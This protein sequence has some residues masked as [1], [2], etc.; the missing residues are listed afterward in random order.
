MDST[1]LK[2][3]KARLQSRDRRVTLKFANKED[4]NRENSKTNRENNSNKKD[5]SRESNK[6]DKENNGKDKNHQGFNNTVLL[7]RQN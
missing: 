3:I 6:I 7:L 1:V 2:D 5:N 4:K